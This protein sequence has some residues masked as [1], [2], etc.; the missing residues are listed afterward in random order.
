MPVDE[1]FLRGRG[2]WGE[3]VIRH[4]LLKQIA[5]GSKM[6]IKLGVPSSKISREMFKYVLH[7]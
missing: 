7:D 6:V 2:E 1:Y 3:V 4:L 5:M